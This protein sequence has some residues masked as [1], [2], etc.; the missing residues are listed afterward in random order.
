MYC[1]YSKFLEIDLSVNACDNLS[2]MV[3]AIICYTMLS[4][5]R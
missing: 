3:K 1:F 5:L 2:E 4:K